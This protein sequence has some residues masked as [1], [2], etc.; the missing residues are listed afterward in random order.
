MHCFVG[1]DKV[2]I[3]IVILEIANSEYYHETLKEGAD[4]AHRAADIERTR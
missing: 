4:I 3:F 2:C 1:A